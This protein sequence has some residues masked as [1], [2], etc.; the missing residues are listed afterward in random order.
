MA[1]V[2]QCRDVGMA[3]DF[4]ARGETEQDVLQ[5]AAA[6]AMKDHGIQ[7]ITPELGAQVKAVIRDE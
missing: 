1:K 3:C 4:V 2:L 5:Q 6:H 7:E